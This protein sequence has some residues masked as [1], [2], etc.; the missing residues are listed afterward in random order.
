[1]FI[2]FVLFSLGSEKIGGR[3]NLICLNVQLRELKLFTSGLG[4]GGKEP[5]AKPQGLDPSYVRTCLGGTMHNA[6]SMLNDLYEE[7]V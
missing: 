7:A 6:Q 2:C 5:R 1:M 4:K 3:V